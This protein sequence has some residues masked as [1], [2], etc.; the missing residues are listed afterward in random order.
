MNMKYIN[1]SSYPQFSLEAEGE[2]SP[3]ILGGVGCNF[4]LGRSGNLPPLAWDKHWESITRHLRDLRTGMLRVGFLPP[5]AVDVATDVEHVTPW[6]DTRQEYNWDHDFFKIVSRL[7]VLGDELGFPIMIDPWSV[8]HSRQIMTS[9]LSDR[10]GYQGMPKDIEQYARTYVLPFV[11]HIVE[12]LGCRRVTHLGLLNEPVWRG[13]DRDPA[14]YAVEEGEDQLVRLT[15]MYSAVRGVLDENSLEDVQ[16]VGPSALCPYQFPMADF[17][18]SGVDPT[19]Y[20]GAFDQHYYLYHSDALTAPDSSYFSTHEV[21][22]GNV[23]R[24]C[25]FARR[26]KKPFFVAEMGSFAY[27]RLFYGERDMEGPASHTCAISDAQFVVR[28][29]NYGVEAFMRWAFSVPQ[30]FD[31]RW[32]FVEWDENNV[33]PTPNIYSMYRELMRAARPGCRIMKMKVGHAAGTRCAVHAVATKHD[34]NLNLLIV[35]DTPGLNHDVVIGDGPW[36]GMTLHRIVVDEVRKGRILDPVEFSGNS[37][38]GTELM[39]TPYSLTV[40]TNRN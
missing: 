23:R 3:P 10:Q 33:R 11:K 2:W 26:Q 17:L 15:E 32:S 25:D 12:D 22:D 28:A 21:V 13:D 36:R 8:P 20:L 40:L 29:L 27:G 19:P 16:L 31:G 14:N 4:F 9:G 34:N 38:E 7:D 5:G 6:D 18:A 24:W 1:L 39:L 37:K 35:N 30:H